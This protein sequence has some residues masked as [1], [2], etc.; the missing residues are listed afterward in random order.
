MES[1]KK[2]IHHQQAEQSY[3]SGS[4]TSTLLW[5]WKETLSANTQNTSKQ[6]IAEPLPMGFQP[7]LNIGRIRW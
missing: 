6:A 1:D 3:G 4:I 5:E 7:L 2:T